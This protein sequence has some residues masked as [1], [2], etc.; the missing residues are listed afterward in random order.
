MIRMPVL[1][2]DTRNY[3]ARL[4]N[5][6]SAFEGK[7]N[8]APGGAQVRNRTRFRHQHMRTSVHNL[9]ILLRPPWASG[10]AV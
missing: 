6:M 2:D 3:R 9:A 7:T 4:P 8:I 1:I 10:W 5:S